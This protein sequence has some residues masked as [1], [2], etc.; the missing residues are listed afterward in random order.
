V[1]CT[2]EF[3]QQ[4]FPDAKILP[5][6]NGDAGLVFAPM[7]KECTIAAWCVPPRFPRRLHLATERF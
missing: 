4:E 1:I 7:S 3:L 2:A 6:V 5:P